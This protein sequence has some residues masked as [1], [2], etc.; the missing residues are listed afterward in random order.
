VNDPEPNLSLD[1][2][3]DAVETAIAL[4][5]NALNKTTLMR[6]SRV[7]EEYNKELVPFATA[8]ERDWTSAAPRLFG[9]TFLKDA[10]DYLQ[11][12]QL[13]RKVKSKPTQVF[14]QGPPSSHQG[15]AE[16]QR[17]GSSHHTL[18]RPATR[19]LILRGRELPRRND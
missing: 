10:A 15:E 14:G 16:D 1:Q 3:G 5:A 4:L 13:V 12:L 6:R 9:P 18:A 17:H 11:Q 2:I 7:L 8:Q 19:R